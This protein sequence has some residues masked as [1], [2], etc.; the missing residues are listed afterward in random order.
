MASEDSDQVLPGFLAIH[1]LDDLS[2]LDQALPIEMPAFCD[3]LDATREL[4]KVR[5][6]RASQRELTEERN[7]RLHQ[8]GS[9]SDEVL[10]EVLLVVVVTLV[11]E[12]PPDSEEVTK[13]FQTRDA[14]H[15]LRH[16]K[17]VKHLI[18]GPVALPPSPV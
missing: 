16:H 8:L 12:D 7:D 10:A 13:I 6:L 18:A 11:Q 17:P 9:P 1:G 4:L 15:A 2:D 5:L 14:L 3:Q